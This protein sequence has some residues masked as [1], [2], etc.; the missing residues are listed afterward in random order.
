MRTIEIN[1]KNKNEILAYD[2]TYFTINRISKYIKDIISEKTY[3]IE[4]FNKLLEE[5]FKF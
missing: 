2:E 3:S 1:G 4:N 5:K